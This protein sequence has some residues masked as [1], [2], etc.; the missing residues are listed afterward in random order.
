M[1]K[2]RVLTA[3]V[4]L[5]LF[6]LALFYLPVVGWMLLTGIIVLLAW[7]EWLKLT[8]INKTS[9]RLGGA[10]LLAGIMYATR[11]QALDAYSISLFGTVLWLVLFVQLIWVSD[12]ILWSRWLRRLVG[13]VVLTIAW[14]LLCWLRGQWEGQWWILGFLC[15]IWIADTGAYFAGRA[16]GKH[17][18]APSISPGKTI[19]GVIGGVVLVCI[20]TAGLYFAVPILPLPAMLSVAILVALVSV[21]GDLYESRLKRM[22]GIKDSSQILPGHG[23]ILDRIDSLIAGLPFFVL[24]ILLVGVF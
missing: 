17:K 9:Y 18:L 4:L 21:G 5:P 8:G 16:L 12:A 10:L 20:A 13:L 24:S 19:E 1:L 23:G 7:D 14:W 11:W 22:E 3:L 15:I 6:L 2:A